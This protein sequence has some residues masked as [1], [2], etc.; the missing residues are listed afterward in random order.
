MRIYME[1]RNI[2]IEISVSSWSSL[3]SYF[4]SNNVYAKFLEN[5]RLLSEFSHFLY[6]LKKLINKWKEFSI[7]VSS[8]SSLISYLLLYHKMIKLDLFYVSVSSRSSLIS[9]V[10][11][12][13]SSSVNEV[14]V[15]VSSRSSLISYPILKKTF[16][17]N[18]L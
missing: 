15:S 4:M 5:F 2:V 9:Y 13:E 12:V 7:S 8:R 10:Q 3:I 1:L 18:R 16:V 17:Y 6:K 11:I 14:K